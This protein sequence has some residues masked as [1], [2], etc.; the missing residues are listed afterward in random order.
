MAIA[1]VASRHATAVAAVGNSTPLDL[2]AGAS[3]A[4]GNHLVLLMALDNSGTSGVDPNCE[5]ISDPV[6]NTWV[7]L[8]KATRTAGVANDGGHVEAWFC[9]VVVPYANGNDI[10]PVFSF[11]VARGC[12][13][14]NEFSGVR[15]ISYPVVGTVTAT[16]SSTT[17][18]PVA[19][20]PTA[21]GQLVVSAAAIETNTAITGDA[22]AT[23]GSW[24]A[25]G[26]TL[27]NSGTDATSVTLSEQYKIV[28]AAGAQS[29]AVT[30]TG[31]AD[32]AALSFVLDTYTPVAPGFSPGNPNF[33]CIAG[34]EN[35]STRARALPIDTGTAYM[36]THKIFPN[37]IGSQDYAMVTTVGVTSSVEDDPVSNH[38]IVGD[39]YLAG[40]ELPTQDPITNPTLFLSAAVLGSGAQTWNPD[41]DSPGAGT[42]LAALS[43]VGG[44]CVRLEN[45]ES[46]DL[47]FNATLISTLF[48]NHRVLRWGIRYVAFKDDSEVPGP[49]NGIAVEVHDTEI[50]AGAG[51][52]YLAGGWLVGNYRGTSQYETR[53]FGEVNGNPRAF[54]EDPLS[55]AAL[56][57]RACWTP[58]DFAYVNLGEIF[59][60]IQAVESDVFIDYIEAV[61]ELTAERREAHGARSV[62]TA[63][64][65]TGT[66]PTGNLLTRMVK[67]ADGSDRWVVLD[68]S[69]TYVLAV[70]EGLPASPSDL[71]PALV[72][73][74]GGQRIV[75]PLEAIGPAL[76]LTAPVGPRATLEPS[77]T[78]RTGVLSLGVLQA[79]PAES[80]SLQGA[81][82][83]AVDAINYPIEGA[84]FL[85]YYLSVFSAGSAAQV[86]SGHDLHQYI[87]VPGGQQYT[88]IKLLV[89]RDDLTTANLSISVQ[90]PPATP[91]ATAVVTIADIATLPDMGSGFTEVSV[92]LSVP[93]NPSAG[94]VYVVLSSATDNN[95][96]WQIGGAIPVSTYLGY[97]PG[98]P[99]F[100][101]EPYDYSVVLQCPLLAPT[102]TMGSTTKDVVVGSDRC[103]AS[104]TTLPELTLTNAD[105]YDY[106]AIYRSADGEDPVP[107]ALIDDPIDNYVFIDYEV[108]WDYP[109]STITYTVVGYRASDHLS[110]ST[111]TTAWAGTSAAP[112][113]AFGLFSNELSLGFAYIPVDGRSLDLEY[114]SLN[115]VEMIQRHG[116]NFQTAIMAAE[117]RGL[118]VSASVVVD[119]L[120]RCGDESPGDYDG[121]RMD[122]SPLDDLRSLERNRRM[123]MKFPGGHSRW[124]HVRVG[125]MNVRVEHG[126]YMGEITLTDCEI[127]LVEPW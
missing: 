50:N 124:V 90:Q 5:G 33:P 11:S 77:P 22:D 14:I 67:A 26:T 70:R 99:T 62:S 20:T 45:G 6:G 105:L 65:A 85:S 82:V 104:T 59:V 28:N 12:F 54:R 86:Y 98:S 84:F 73:L 74:E 18:G 116:V 46:V 16:G 68:T 126:V 111:T 115:Q 57:H 110:A 64:Y 79:L 100:S 106:V 24:S 102:Y 75:A 63:P 44:E 117:E 17:I 80:D 39:L 48:S 118:A 81:S 66:Y 29:W 94:R 108:P 120:G 72:A 36:F 71:Y 76:Q 1:F 55:V 43:A 40:G 25:I 61:V 92:A 37:D 32:F 119:R 51:G 97:D 27:S 91:I 78:I 89:G 9:R 123:L 83:A 127:P 69:A 56:P 38:T 109:I 93:I 8:G 31:A 3:I 53:W 49:S 15:P 113:A 23:N 41:S 101:T 114:R 34:P 88:R 42:A 112:G 122:P 60:R 125:T 2:A 52:S 96:A 58:A 30:K 87:A 21:T 35:L 19:I 4:V 7:R 10:T 47:T 107:A 95:A 13:G 121:L 103:T